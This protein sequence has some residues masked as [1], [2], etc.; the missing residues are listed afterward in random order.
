MRCV[1][2]RVL[3]VCPTCSP[4]GG[5]QTWLD[6]VA[7]G[8]ATFGWDPIVALVHGPTTN[9]SA[10]YRK[11]HPKL[12]TMIIDGSGM[13]MAARV[14]KVKK[15]IA[16]VKPELYVPLTVID[17]HDAICLLKQQIS[18][19]PKY[20]LSVHGNLPQQIADVRLFQEFADVAINPG[21]LTCELVKRSGMPAD[22]IVHIPNGTRIWGIRQPGS[23]AQAL[24]LAYVGRLTDS[25]KRVLD[26]IPLVQQLEQEGV[27]YHLDIVG[28]GP[29]EAH[30]R[31]NIRLPRVQFHGFVPPDILHRDFYPQLD[32]LLMFSQS[33]AFGISLIEAMSHGV[34]PVSS[35]FIG[36]RAEG[37]LIDHQTARLF[38]IGDIRS[39]SQIMRDVAVDRRS[40]SEV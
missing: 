14:R 11:T 7:L 25:D 22:R 39:C 23:P 29:A 5:L 13:T 36:S 12:N 38:E 8:L 27:N 21:R 6:E 32:A 1:R 30:L 2:R 15:T 19:A 37:F 26:L 9:D 17:A 10:L 31:E 18:A 40:L 16:R 4:Y 3:F 20:V 28:A 33:E 24:R 35:R 34:V